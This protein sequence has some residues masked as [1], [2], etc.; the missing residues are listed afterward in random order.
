MIHAEPAMCNSKKDDV[1]AKRPMV[2]AR[3]AENSAQQTNVIANSIPDTGKK[4]KPFGENA[5]FQT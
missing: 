1:P 4:S 5:W 2:K 3:G